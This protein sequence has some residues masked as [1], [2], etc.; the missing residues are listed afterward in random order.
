MMIYAYKMMHDHGVAPCV[1]N[2]TLTLAICAQQIRKNA[3]KDGVVLGI[4]G[5]NL[6]LGR[7][8]YAAKVTETFGPGPDYYID[9]AHL[10]R[11]DCIYEP[12]VNGQPVQRGPDW[13]HYIDNKKRHWGEDVGRNWR[14]ARVLK[15]TDF[16]YLGKRGSVRLLLAYPNLY[17]LIRMSRREIMQKYGQIDSRRIEWPDLNEVINDLFAY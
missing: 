10:D 1:E 15:S 13:G 9:P 11:Q 6:G 5:R 8:I 16:R 14:N 4:G 2:G 17:P 7:L 12:D 3:G